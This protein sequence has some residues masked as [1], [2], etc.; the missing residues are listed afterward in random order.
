M[1]FVSTVP[2]T[3]SIQVRVV[4]RSQ[5]GAATAIAG[6]QWLFIVH[7]ISPEGTQHLAFTL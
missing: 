3:N 1:Q 4:S 7:P 6:Y 2:D 5:I